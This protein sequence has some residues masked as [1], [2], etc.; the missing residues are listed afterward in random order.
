MIVFAVI[1]GVYAVKMVGIIF[2]T[3]QRSPAMQL[4]MWIAYLSVPVGIILLGFRAIENVLL[5]VKE[6]RHRKERL[7]K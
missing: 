3:G 1:F 5:L 7:D 6:V 4:P 2:Q